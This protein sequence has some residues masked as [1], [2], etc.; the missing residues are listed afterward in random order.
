MK[1]CFNSYILL[2]I[3]FVTGGEAV[4]DTKKFLVELYDTNEEG[5]VNK[6]GDYMTGN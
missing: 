4:D 5:G 6:M 2:S 3:I 1:L